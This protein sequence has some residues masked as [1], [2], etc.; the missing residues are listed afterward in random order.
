MEEAVEEARDAL[1]LARLLVRMVRGVRRGVL[2]L[3]FVLEELG[4][5]EGTEDEN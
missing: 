3:P 5:V 1:L 2:L 4:W